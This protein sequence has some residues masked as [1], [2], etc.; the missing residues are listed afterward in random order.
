MY[1][2]A[3]TG[4][5]QAPCCYTTAMKMKDRFFLPLEGTV[6]GA[7]LFRQRDEYSCGPACLASAAALYSIASVDYGKFRD[8]LSP[9]PQ[10][11]SDN[12]DMAAAAE[13]HLPFVSAGEDCYAGGIAIAN[14]IQEEGHYVLFLCGEAGRVAYYDPYHH[15]LCEESLADIEWISESGHLKR[16]CIN[17]APLEGNS[18]SRWRQLA[19]TPAAVKTPPQEKP[20]AYMPR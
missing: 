7:L 17:L 4:L 5:A 6:L 15:E 14:I 8:I 1:K 10:T 20:A 13:A 11:G 12:F 3:E 18:I 16:W 9:N 2:S 19:Q